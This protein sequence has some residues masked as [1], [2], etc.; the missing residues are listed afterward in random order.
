M[1]VAVDD[2]DDLGDTAKTSA[3]KRNP[4]GQNGYDD[5]SGDDGYDGDSGNDGYDDD[6]VVMVMIRDRDDESLRLNTSSEASQKQY[7]DDHWQN[8]HLHLIILLG[9]QK[10]LFMKVKIV[11]EKS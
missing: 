9:M 11:G 6:S 10:S 2:D 5:D 7:K 8:P 3:S 1:R 4:G